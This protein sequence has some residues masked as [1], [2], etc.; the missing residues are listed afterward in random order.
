MKYEG[1]RWLILMSLM[2]ALCASGCREDIKATADERVRETL[3]D[4]QEKREAIPFLETGGRF[5]DPDATTTVDRDV[6][7]PLLKRLHEISPTE[8]WAI[9]RPNDTTWAFALLIELPKDKPTVERMAE[10]VLEAEGKFSGMI[11]QQ[12]GHEWLSVDFIDEKGA[13]MMKKAYPGGIKWR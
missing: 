12:W 1:T 8:Q 9:I 3:L 13:E 10:V 6:V 11:L 5:K 2:V 7:L 4:T